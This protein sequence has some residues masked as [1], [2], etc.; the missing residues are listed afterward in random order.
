VSR[1]L[2]PLI[3]YS[4]NIYLEFM[5]TLGSFGEGSIT[6]TPGGGGQKPP[7]MRAT[8]KQLFEYSIYVFY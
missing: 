7:T 1:G 2:A 8:G 4:T 6:L 5:T 3:I